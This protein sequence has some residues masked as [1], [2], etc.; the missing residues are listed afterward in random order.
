[1]DSSVVVIISDIRAQDKIIRFMTV[2]DT[3]LE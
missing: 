2:L 3:A 1:M